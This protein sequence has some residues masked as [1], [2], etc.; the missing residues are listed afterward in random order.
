MVEGTIF[1]ILFRP[2][3]RKWREAAR[4]NIIQYQLRDL[5]A[6]ECEIV[7]RKILLTIGTN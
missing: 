5:Y 6:I 7:D 2:T 4:L 1:N 3:R